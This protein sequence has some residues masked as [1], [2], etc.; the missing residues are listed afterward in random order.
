MSSSLKNSKKN[1]HKETKLNKLETKEAE[2]ILEKGV[3]N[4]YLSFNLIHK[5][6]QEK[7]TFLENE[8]NNL[9]KK[10][11]TLVKEIEMVQR[12]NKYYKENN[13]KLRNEIEKLNKLVSNIKGKLTNDDLEINKFLKADNNKNLNLMKFYTKNNNK[14]KNNNNNFYLYNAYKKN[15]YNENKKNEKNDLIN[16]FIDNKN[17]SLN[18][19][20]ENKKNCKNNSSFNLQLDINNFYHNNNGNKGKFRSSN[21]FQNKYRTAHISREEKFKRK[22]NIDRE[23][24]LHEDLF[25]NRC[26]S[27]NKYNNDKIENNKE[28]NLESDLNIED[29]NIEG[30]NNIL[31]SNNNN[32]DYNNAENNNNKNKKFGHKV[33]LTYDNLFNNNIKEINKKKNTYSTFRGKIFS[34]NNNK[35]E[36]NIINEKNKGKEKVHLFLDKCKNNLEQ[37]SF[38]KIVNIFHD[39]KEGLITDKGII[40]Q[41]KKYIWNNKGLIELFNKTFSK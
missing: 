21:T 39:Y 7:I 26:N 33:C 36:K 19:I 14:F 30:L 5:N 15:I 1:I 12:E 38:E 13:I 25:N 41:I 29:L 16:F 28:E 34:E 24:D 35:S 3:E 2:E 23:E 20:T 40:V 27:S 10:I 18:S 32:I 8:I 17:D 6:Y 22:N 37:E 31:L 9:S 4:I 11:E